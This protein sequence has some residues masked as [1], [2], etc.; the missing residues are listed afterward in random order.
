MKTF[1]DNEILESD[2]SKS[3][4]YP[5][6]WK[7]HCYSYSNFILE[8]LW[9][10]DDK[11]EDKPM[12]VKCSWWKYKF[13]FMPMVNQLIEDASD[14]VFN[15]FEK[16]IKKIRK[17]TDREKNQYEIEQRAAHKGWDYNKDQFFK[18][19]DA[20]NLKLQTGVPDMN[21]SPELVSETSSR[22]R[23][24]KNKNKHN[25]K[26]E[27]DNNN[28]NSNN[29]NKTGHKRSR[30]AM[31]I[32][33]E[34]ENELS[35]QDELELENDESDESLKEMQSPPKKK[36]RTVGKLSV[37]LR[38][39]TRE[40]RKILEE[41][42][43]EK[44]MKRRNS[45]ATRGR[46]K[47]VSKS[48]GRATR[49]RTKAT[50][51][52]G[53]AISRIAGTRRTGQKN[54]V[55]ASTTPRKIDELKLDDSNDDNG[56]GSDSGSA[57]IYERVHTDDED[58]DINVRSKHINEKQDEMSDDQHSQSEEKDD[59][60]SET[61]LVN[62]TAGGIESESADSSPAVE[63]TKKTKRKR[64]GTG[65]GKGK[66][67]S[68]SKQG[69]INDSD[70]DGINPNSS[71]GMLMNFV[72]EAMAQE[73]ISSTGG[74]VAYEPDLS[75]LANMGRDV[76]EAEKRSTKN[77]KSKTST[78]NNSKT[79]RLITKTPKVT[80][81]GL[82]S[83]KAGTSDYDNSSDEEERPMDEHCGYDASKA[84]ENCLVWITREEFENLE[85][86]EQAIQV[87]TTQ[88]GFK[89]PSNSFLPTARTALY[90]HRAGY[91]ALLPRGLMFDKSINNKV[92]TCIFGDITIKIKFDKSYTALTKLSLITDRKFAFSF[93]EVD[94]GED[95]KSTYIDFNRGELDRYNGYFNI[96]AFGNKT[97]AGAYS[98]IKYLRVVSI[99][100]GPLAA[101]DYSQQK[102]G[103]YALR[104]MAREPLV[105]YGRYDPTP[106]SVIQQVR[107]WQMPDS[108]IKDTAHYLY[109]VI[110]QARCGLVNMID[111]GVLDYITG[112]FKNKDIPL[113]PQIMDPITARFNLMNKK[114]KFSI[115]MY[116]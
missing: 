38:S 80:M 97:A 8:I 32:R 59:E 5:V 101:F 15:W 33:S 108:A 92:V 94:E 14:A 9:P 87:F 98:G 16:P 49:G 2:D 75:Q 82:S 7:N 60:I 99:N 86:D 26:K 76:I 73:G 42:I 90:G 52:R 57:T 11:L 70:D 6:E 111:T 41:K 17:C 58:S 91:A 45:K 56:S 44:E 107:N 113:M 55:G 40:K 88:F 27:N 109:L 18:Y 61:Q 96:P 21:Q 29:N 35:S 116:H 63:K 64:K 89:V 105:K 20:H 22:P 1:V 72:D 12:V 53:G 81:R 69:D 77:A 4:T 39:A 19:I 51:G 31:S 28:D 3:Q 100:I 114:K 68:K 10:I 67:K 85:E 25:K 93:G 46:G 37:E 54:R 78:K 13:D 115:S 48:V 30:S 23:R 43:K 66:G 83:D 102:G 65:K 50:R 112:R 47:G 34:S 71:I 24:N 95:K 110:Q 62:E 104:R 74:T 106:M 36:Q 84:E 79:K 103:K